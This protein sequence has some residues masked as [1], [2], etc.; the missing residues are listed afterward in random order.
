MDGQPVQT[1]RSDS[2]PVWLKHRVEAG[3]VEDAFFANLRAAHREAERRLAAFGPA[4]ALPEST[5]LYAAP[6]RVLPGGI[7]ALKRCLQAHQDAVGRHLGGEASRA[8]RVVQVNLH[9]F[10]L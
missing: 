9:C 2:Y 1:F 7:P 8:T 6:L 4:V 10:P 3:E 5:H